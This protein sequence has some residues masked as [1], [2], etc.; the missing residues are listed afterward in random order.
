M[1]ALWFASAGSFFL[2]R[3]VFVNSYA[4]VLTFAFFANAWAATVSGYVIHGDSGTRVAAVEVAFL[5]TQDGQNSEILRKLTDD[6]GRFSFDGPFI[7]AGVEFGLVAFYGGASY[8]TTMLRVG[9]QKEIILEV[10][11]STER[12]DKIRIANHHLFLNLQEPNLEVGN[13]VEVENRGAKTFRG[14][15]SGNARRVT[16]FTLPLGVFNV[17]GNLRQTGA[18]QFFDNQPLPPG[19][20]QTSFTFLL[21]AQELNE[22]Y[23][24]VSNYEIGTLNIYLQPSSL[25]PEG[26]FQ[27]LGEVEFHGTRYRHL[28]LQG[29][30]PGQP[31]LIP[32]P[33]AKSLRWLVKWATLGLAILGAAL[34]IPFKR[35]PPDVPD[36]TN[37][38]QQLEALLNELAH[39]DDANTAIPT[40]PEYHSQRICLMVRATDLRRQLDQRVDER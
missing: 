9:A 4:F 24:F 34:V 20:T 33:V 31:V 40:D 23:R 28:H 29:L 6:E 7:I 11:P 19:R 5:I 18:Q 26:P 2:S 37:L 8:P 22:G 35:H 36:T 1:F 15:G 21:N 17:G 25:S 14:A 27:N 3:L 38:H 10:F 39:L 32:L 30:Q 12:G 13:L 16:E